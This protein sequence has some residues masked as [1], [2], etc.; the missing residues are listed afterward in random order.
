MSRVLAVVGARLSSSR[1]P[2]KQLLDLAG[3]PLIERIFQRLEHVPQIDRALVATTAETVNQPLVEWAG[4]AGREVFV[5]HGDVD[6]V[7]G[8]VDAVVEREKPEIVVYVCGDSPLIDPGTITRMIAAL[9]DHPETDH[10][11]ID[12]RHGRQAIHEGFYPYRYRTWRRIVDAANE[13]AER[14]HVGTSIGHVLPQLRCR[15]VVD[16]DVFYRLEHRISVDTPSDYQF[17]AEVYRRWYDDHPASTI[18]SLAWVI[19]MLERDAALRAE[20]SGVR[21]KGAQE[22]GIKALVVTQCGEGVGLGHLSRSIVVAR[23]LQDTLSAGVQILIQGNHVTYQGLQWLPHRFISPDDDLAAAVAA[24]VDDSDAVVFDL[25]PAHVPSTLTAVLEKLHGQGIVSVAVDGLFEWYAQLDHIFVPSFFLGQAY[26]HLAT[27]KH[28]TYGWSNYLLSPALNDQPWR[29][30]NRVLVMTGGSDVAGLSAVWPALLDNVLPA[31][32]V[33]DWVQG[34]YAAAPLLP[35]QPR[36]QWTI[37][38]NPAHLAALLDR[39]HYGLCVYG[40]SFFE[41]LK[42]GKPCVTWVA[43]QRDMDEEI[44]ALREENVAIVA[45]SADQA[46]SDLA[47][48]MDDP[49]RAHRLGNGALLKLSGDGPDL[50]A[51]VVAGL[52]GERKGVRNPA[53]PA[54]ASKRGING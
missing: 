25:A 42:R 7:V 16:D 33:V 11:Y 8:R 34:P 23:A 53:A 38:H 26:R 3:Q 29:P 21:Q 47:A 2:G 35:N 31:D 22:R 17:M 39:A 13:E 45:P 44:Q 40:V 43:A 41:L 32:S 20:N 27:N 46:V 30:G 1:L 19:E 9:Q 4:R 24:N 54:S 49:H 12:K 51:Q 52:I 37:H 18:V 10:V 50:F 15:S 5:Y 6:D 14:E 36:L 48:L 28:V